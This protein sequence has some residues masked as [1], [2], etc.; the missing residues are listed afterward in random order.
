MRVY[1]WH[2]LLSLVQINLSSF[3]DCSAQNLCYLLWFVCLK[4]KPEVYKCKYFISVGYKDSFWS[5]IIHVQINYGTEV[6]VDDEII[7]KAIFFLFNTTY[8]KINIWKSLKEY[9]FGE[10][11]YLFCQNHNYLF[12]YFFYFDETCIFY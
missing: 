9:N 8:I 2:V 5:T 6:R 12:M 10:K 4:L 3:K 1:S 7:F 11:N